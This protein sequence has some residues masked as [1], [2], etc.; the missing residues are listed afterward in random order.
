MDL[1]HCDVMDGNFVPNLTFGPGFIQDLKKHTAIPLDVHLMIEKP[2][3]SIDQYLKVKPWA[4]DHP[5]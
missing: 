5:L 3:R 4:A 1:L 2:E